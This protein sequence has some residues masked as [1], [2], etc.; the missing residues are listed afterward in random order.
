MELNLGFEISQASVNFIDELLATQID[1]VAQAYLKLFLV[2]MSV[3]E[4]EL[5]LEHL[6]SC[7]DFL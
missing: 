1:F 4:F 5:I 2:V 7:A 6:D 3:G